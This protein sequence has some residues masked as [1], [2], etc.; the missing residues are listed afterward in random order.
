MEKKTMQ[1]LQN[2]NMMNYFI[3]LVVQYLHNQTCDFIYWKCVYIEEQVSEW[4][5]RASE[6][7]N[8]GILEWVSLSSALNISHFIPNL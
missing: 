8:D 3:K 5:M 1:I 6:R 7:A 2:I 4:F